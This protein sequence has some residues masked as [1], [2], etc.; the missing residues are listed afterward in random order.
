MLTGTPASVVAGNTGSVTVTAKDA[1]GNTTPAYTGTITFSSNDALASLPSDYTFTGGD[2]GVKAFPSSYTLKTA[3]S[4]TLTATDTGNG[5]IA[6]TSGSITVDPAAAATLTVSAAPST[7]S[8]GGSTNATITAK[9]AFGNTATGYTGTVHLTS[10]DG[11][12]VLPGDYTFVGGDNGSHVL[13]VTLKTAGSQTATATDTGNGSITGTSNNV[14]VNPAA[15]ATLTVA[16]SSPVTA[17]NS[18]SVT[19]TAKDAF[20]NTATGYTGTVH[21]TSTDG[22]AVLPADYTFTGGDAGVH[23]F[24]ATLKTAGTRTITATDTVTG[25]ITGTSNNVT[26]NPAATATLTVSAAPSTVTAGNS[27]N[28]TVTAK[29]AYNNTVTGYTGTVHLTSTDGAAVLP[30]DYTFVGGDNGSHVL[31]VTLKTAGSQTATATD[32]VTGSINGTSNNVT[33][34]PAAAATLVLSGT[35]GSVTAG[36][37]ANVT[38]TALDAYGNTDTGYTGTVQLTSSDGAAVLPGNHTFTGGDAGVHV[39][40]NAYTL[41]TAGPQTLTATDTGNGSITGTSNNVTVDPAAAATLTVSAASPVTAGNSTNVTVTAKDA[42]NNTATGYTGTVHLT[43]TDGAAVLPGD[44]TFVGGDNGS[45]VLAV[46]L[47]TAGTRTI[48]ATDTGNGSITGTSNNI[49]VDPAAA[50]TFQVTT[51]GTATAGVA[52]SVTVTAKDAY[53]N[54]AT[55]YTGIAHFTSTDGAA[56]LP[57]NYTF[58]GGDA[59]THVFS[60]TLK[61]AGTQ[62]VT[63]TDTVTGSITG[64][65]G[66]VT[67]SPAAAA[68]LTVSA[69][70]STVT[71]GNSTNATVT[72]KDSYGNVATGYTGTVHLT[73]TDGAAVLPADYTF[74]GGDN[75]SHVL[76]VTLKTAGTRTITATDTGNGSITGASNNITVDPAAAASFDLTGTPAT[77]TAGN[78]AGVTV[79][80]RDAYN[81]IATGYT[82][83]AHFTSTDALATLPAN[84]TFVAGDFGSHAF[85]ATLETAGSQTTTATDTVTATITGTSPTVAVSP[86][87]VA[88]L[89]LTGTPAS[90]T[91][92]NSASVTVTA[93]DAYQNTV[94]TYTGTVHFTSSDAQAVLPANYTFTGGDN[95]THAFSATLKTAGSQTLA[96]ADT[97]TGSI[98]GTS[99]GITVDAA[100]VSGSASTAAASPTSVPADGSTASTVTVTLTDAFGNPVSGKTVSLAQTGSSSISSASGPSSAGGVVTFTVTS[101]VAETVT[102]TATDSTDAVT[103]TQTPSVTFAIGSLDHIAIT[104]SSSTVAAGV[105]QGYTVEAFDAF[106]N[107]LGDVTGGTSFGIT[108]DGSCPGAGASCSATV[109]GAHTVTATYAGKTDTSTLTVVSAPADAAASTISAAPGSITANGSSTSAVTVQLKDIFGNNRTSGTN[110]VALATTTGTLTAVTD[111]GN[112]TYSATLTSATSVGTAS[113]TGTL[114]GVAIVSTASVIFTPGAATHLAVTGAG[115]TTAGVP[116]SVVVTAKDAFNNTAT[117]YAGTVTFTSSD[118]GATLPSD[119]TFVGGDSGSHTFSAT[120]T[121]AGSQSVTATDTGTGSINGSHSIT[122]DPAAAA[123]FVVTPAGGPQTAGGA[124]NVTVTAKDAFGNVATGY[125]GTVHFTSTDGQAAIP[126][127]Y[128]FTGGDAGTHT[129][130]TTLKT[131]GSQTVTVTQGAVTGTTPSITVNPGA[132]SVFALTGVPLTVVSGVPASVT[133]TAQDAYTNTVTG[134]TGTVHFSSNDPAATLPG[135]YTFTGGDAGVHTFSNAYTLFTTGARNVAAA[136]TISPAVTGTSAFITVTP[137]AASGATSTI[138]A[139]P[140]SIQANGTSTSALTVQLKDVTGNDLTAGGN[141][142][143]LSATNGGTIGAITDHGNGTYTATLTSSTVAGVSSVSGTVDLAPIAI[144]TTVTFTPG[145]AATFDVSGPATAAAGSTVSFTVTA[146]D[147]YGNTATGYTGAVHVTSDDPQAVLPANYTFTGGDAGVHTFSAIV[148]KSAGNRT[149]TATDTVTSS[150]TGTSSGTAVSALGVDAAASTVTASPTPV[151]ADGSSAT[152]VTVTLKDQYGNRVAGKAVAVSNTGSATLSSGGTGTSDAAGVATFTSTDAVPESVTYSA[153]G[154]GVTLTQQATVNFTTGTLDHIVVSPSSA[155]ISADGGSQ[156]Y[157]V[158][159]YDALNNSL[160]D[161]APDMTFTISPDGTCTGATCSATVSG[162]HTVTATDTSTGT[163]SNT[164][165]LNVNAGAPSTVTSTITA[166]PGSV[167]ADNTTSTITVRLKDAAGNNVP[168]SGGTVALSTTLGTLSSVTDNANG[169]YTA[170]VKSTLVGTATITGTLNAAAFASSTGVTFVPGPA[171][172]FVVT[173]P[174]SATAGS[175][176][177]VTLTAKD[178]FNNTAT[179]YL[180]T[181]HF[182]STDGPATL[183]GDYGFVSGDAGVNTFPVTLKTAGSQTVTATDTITATINGTTGA[184]GVSPGPVSATASTMTPASSSVLADNSTTTPVHVT[185]KDAFGNVVPGKTV[186]LGAGAGSSS[187]APLSDV[188]DGSGMANFAV[189]DGTVETVTYNAVDTSD[190]LPLNDTAQVSFTP[191]LLASVTVNPASATVQAGVAQAYTVRGFD[192]FGHD[193]GD[194]TPASTF[195]INP[196]GTC[197]GASCTATIVGPHTV[198]VTNTTNGTHTTTASLTVTPAAANAAATTITASPGTITANGTSTSAITV[199]AK[200]QYNNSLATGGATVALATT[201]GTLSAVTDNTNGTYTATLTSASSPGSGTVSG[202]LNAT[203]IGNTATVTFSAIVPGPASG[204]TSTITASPNAIQ[205]DGISTST[206]TVQ[207]KDAAGTN[208]GT[209]GDTVALATTGGATLSSVVDHLNGT[210]TATLTSPVTVGSGTVSGTVN[211]AAITSTATV[212]FTAG[213]PPVPGPASGATSTITASPTSIVANGSS[214]STITVRLKD[215]SGTNLTAGGD[216]VALATTGGATLSSVV[217]NNNGTYTA[218]LTSPVTAGSA[219]VSG[220]VN[221]AAITS[222]ATVTLTAAGSPP[223]LLTAT[224]T[225][226]TLVLTYDQPLDG[227]SVPAPSDFN[228]VQNLTS[229]GTPTGVSV[230]GSTVTISLAAA[231]NPGDA[232]TVDYTG[233]A[234][235]NLSG[236]LA[237]TFA[238]YPVTVGGTPPTPPSGPLTCVRPLLINSDGNACVPPPPPPPPIAFLGA[239]PADGS[240]LGSIGSITLK[241][242]HNASWYG[243]TVTRDGGSA[244]SLPSGAGASY[245]MPFTASAPGTYTITATMDDGYNPAQTVHSQFTIVAS[246]IP[247]IGVADTRGSVSANDG[248]GS[249]SWPAGTFSDPVIVRIDVVTSTGVVTVPPGSLAYQVTATRLRDG[250][251][252]HILGN[253]LDVQFKNAPANATPSTSEDGLAWTT[254]PTLPALSLP[255]GQPDG[256]F[257]DSSNTVHILTRHLSYFALFVP[258]ATKLAFQVVGTVRYT[259]GVDKYVGARISLTQAAVVTARLYS[260]KGVKLK[261]WVRP[262]KAG[263]SILKL[264]LP[265][266]ARKPG[267]YRIAFTARAKSATAMQTIKVRVLPTLKLG[268]TRNTQSRTVV[269]S[270]PAGSAIAAKLHGIRTSVVSG[271]ADSAFRATANISR[272]VVVIVIDADQAGIATIRDLHTIFPDVRILALSGDASLLAHAVP[273][274]ATV[275]L[276]S[277]TS[278]ALV[279]KTVAR[280]AAL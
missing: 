84:Y 220:T 1:Y 157:T 161:V 265:P 139:S 266:T 208:L 26:V 45:H 77:L 258:S 27:T 273:A 54:T 150:I 141:A 91:A 67:V 209:G 241:A 145:P 156:A 78:S 199:Q 168:I 6:G 196:D 247:G 254:V 262:A 279:A 63:A 94:T 270:A 207:L 143:A 250:S 180:G 224:A 83:I 189:K 34:N 142:V 236:Q 115:S 275:A 159:G 272:N 25:S 162:A 210:Y 113:I 251:P 119:Y 153:T 3:G 211:A 277:S 152:T 92:G 53:N 167:V 216:T 114:D 122:V 124:F 169:T 271:G 238:N 85:S 50:A 192:A 44:Y 9:D 226:A 140:T 76:A 38:I 165:T 101:V 137:G 264:K 151:V 88:S 136:D 276:P 13:A 178:A 248:I 175:S 20:N 219:T 47:K 110:I 158:T 31:A 41:K 268:T 102:Y 24:S 62:T 4:R 58:T 230:S 11:A 227:T 120:L 117:G 59:G 181:V 256:A 97:V 69:A 17:G 149:V 66:N 133:V 200:D 125:V 43:S 37:S 73:S 56:V 95:G 106:N 255:D 8:A 12:A 198:I 187:W 182:T 129:F 267:T 205:A 233:T 261:T 164:A 259:W 107:S 278:A 121:T 126:A 81:N 116:A 212:T 130:S 138:V 60:A 35:P 29:D 108:P 170:T 186:T 80:A 213:P 30:A 135:D 173:G 104:P 10:T 39:F 185:L 177:T 232:V 274:G 193:L 146:K 74:T 269:L 239:S 103:L 206:I 15:A 22:A 235:K 86:A 87:A 183:P 21:L 218:T 147:L 257:R 215:A 214:T 98:N 201:G 160:G 128:T 82:G 280:L 229:Q 172:H 246:G 40:T 112:G 105:S 42:F 190:A 18:T 231:V 52:S 221:A 253:V 79:T 7:V 23:V 64:T 132:V 144:G 176:F 131:A 179:G 48:T 217:D 148:L 225:A 72:A 234:L 5:S 240:I 155:S 197:T 28:V 109:V 89:A 100:A 118:G 249:A 154:D 46:T 123:S 174:G 14:T 99:P 244:Q 57:A 260:P 70:P 61:T 202:T 16:A 263:N 191:G 75:G 204:A 163:I 242:N 36:N 184:V 245:T 203:A 166:S 134:Y 222:T 243:I 195:A 111:N 171:S 93:Q 96:A 194:V 68:T 32:T 51:A 188:T 90:V 2:N 223:A 252:V 33:V 127:D 49:T 71:A 65:T 228:V 237:P 55:G 19:V